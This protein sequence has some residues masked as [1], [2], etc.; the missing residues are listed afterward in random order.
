MS[1]DNIEF[2]TFQKMDFEKKDFAFMNHFHRATLK[3]GMTEW[4]KITPNPKRRN[5]GT[6]ENTRK[7]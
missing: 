4:R 5:H 7:S 2:P 1:T 6:A 3:A